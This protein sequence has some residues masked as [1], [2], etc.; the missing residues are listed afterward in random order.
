MG[1]NRPG[2]VDGPG[3]IQ[4]LWVHQTSDGGTKPDVGKVEHNQRQQ[5]VG[6]GETEKTDKGQSMVTPTVLVGGGLNTNRESYQVDKNDGGKIQN[7]GKH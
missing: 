4:V 5:E 2:L 7:H 3:L 1:G 6:S